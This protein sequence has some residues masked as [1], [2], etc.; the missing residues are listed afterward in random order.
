MKNYWL[1]KMVFQYG[2]SKCE[3]K[4]MH[5][6]LFLLTAGNGIINFMNAL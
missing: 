3:E 6:P 2:L 5:N 1:A 4:V